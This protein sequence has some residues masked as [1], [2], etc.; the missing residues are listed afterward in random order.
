[1]GG[2]GSREVRKVKHN[3]FGE[4]TKA[5]NFNRDMIYVVQPILN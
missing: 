1:M 2:G 5:K 3:F 4:V